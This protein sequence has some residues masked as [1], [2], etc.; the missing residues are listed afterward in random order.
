MCVID[1][2]ADTGRESKIN[3]NR[4]PQSANY[5]F[6]A[7]FKRDYLG[8]PETLIKRSLMLLKTNIGTKGY[9]FLETNVSKRESYST[10]YCI[11]DAPAI[12]TGL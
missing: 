6:K 1:G 2:C 8:L 11:A 12:S 4:K 7:P 9:G 10:A 3:L 5:L